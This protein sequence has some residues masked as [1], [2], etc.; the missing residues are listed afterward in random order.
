MEIIEGKVS[1]YKGHGDIHRFY[2]KIGEEIKYY[3]LDFSPLSNGNMIATTELVEAIDSEV[4]ASHIGLVDNEGNVI[5]PLENKTVKPI[6]G[7]ILLVERS[8]PLSQNVL[9][10]IEASKD[11]KLATGLVSITNTCKN[12][13]MEKLGVS[14]ELIFHNQLSE[15]S[16]FDINGN[17]LVNDEYFSY[18]GVNA[19]K[20]Y[21]G[22]NLVDAPITE[23]S[24]LPPEI[25]SNTM[26]PDNAP[27][28]ENINVAEAANNAEEIK[29][30]VEGEM[31]AQEEQENAEVPTTE[32]PVEAP[33]DVPTEE[34]PQEEV[35]AEVPAEAVPVP[36]TEVPVEE[37]AP[38]EAPIEAPTEEAP[39]EEVPAEVPAEETPVPE[40]EV[41]VEEPAPQE[42]VNANEGFDNI[43]LPDVPVVGETPEETE[44]NPLENTSSISPEEV[45][46]ET[47]EVN[48]EEVEP[49]PSVNIINDENQDNV[50]DVLNSLFGNV[51]NNIVEPA[52]VVDV[53][54]EEEPIPEAEVPV[55]EPAQVEEPVEEETPAEEEV[56]EETPIE[57]PAPEEEPIPEAEVPEEEPVPEPAPV[58]EEPVE[59]PTPV[60]EE[61]QEE[62]PVAEVPIEVPIP[63]PEPEE[64]PQEEEKE[65]DSSFSDL[66]KTNNDVDN[67][68]EDTVSSNDY[69]DDN[70]NMFSDFNADKIEKDNDFEYNEYE[71]NTDSYEESNDYGTI[72]EYSSNRDDI[73]S[74]AGKVMSSLITLNRK[75][76][77]D[78]NRLNNEIS[79]ANNNS[80]AKSEKIDLLEN[81]L[82]SASNKVRN[83][84]T[85]V[86]KLESKN[87]MLSSKVDDQKRLIESQT[88][89][90]NSKER[91]IEELRRQLQGKEELAKFIADA[92]NLLGQNEY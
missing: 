43:D 91:E 3:F 71:Y 84:D 49:E 70:Y 33:A 45:A 83:L 51:P 29:D 63:E 11:T 82:N 65:Y 13:V 22:K 18:I 81:K 64:G 76:K 36:E 42:P 21:L 9:D 56:Q 62:P 17:N 37:P 1:N 32:A 24:M 7:D 90:L 10:A 40:A 14:S 55:E 2:G 57:E 46:S 92:Q 80:R 23:Y 88:R 86:N 6:T 12:R 44:V 69:Y 53:P 28:E 61:V 77:S 19:D 79:K 47:A 35:P 25:Q 4:P 66:I 15:A 41:P 59:E 5:I 78:I 20:V 72:D 31:A 34:A 38:T 89:E 85:M 39:Q 60:E 50:D 58:E 8:N 74:S 26:V 87:T 73:L 52:P 68:V 27:V 30:T 75:Q 48:R 16:I 54:T 67:E